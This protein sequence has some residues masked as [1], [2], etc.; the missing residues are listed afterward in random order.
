MTDSGELGDWVRARKR[1]DIFGTT[2][3]R[4]IW[5]DRIGKF[6]YPLPPTWFKFKDYTSRLLLIGQD[7]AEEVIVIEMQAEAWGEHPIPYITLEEQFSFLD[8][9]TFKENIVYAKRAGFPD[10][11]LWG[12]EWWYWLDKTQNHPEFWQH[13]K[14]LF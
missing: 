9:E 10:I 2:M 5:N 13:A 7:Y 11:Y 6:E 12:V 4:F 3:Y 8:F 14:T 1:G